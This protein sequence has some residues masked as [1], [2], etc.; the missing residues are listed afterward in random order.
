MVFTLCD[1]CARRTAR[2]HILGKILSSTSAN[3]PRPPRPPCDRQCVADANC[4]PVASLY[5][6]EEAVR[7]VLPRD[8]I[9]EISIDDLINQAP[10]FLWT[11]LVRMLWSWIRIK[12][13]QISLV[14]RLDTY[15]LLANCLNF[16]H[17]DRRS[18][19]YSDRPR[20]IMAS[21]ILTGGIFMVFAKYGE[22]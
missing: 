15:S 8:I 10:C 2:H 4:V 22:V 20:L 1:L 7:C 19:L 14:S 21:E 13:Q 18:S 3:A 16:S 5:G 11:W 6:V 17:P 12:P 9:Y